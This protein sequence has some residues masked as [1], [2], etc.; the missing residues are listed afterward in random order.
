MSGLNGLRELMGADA[1]DEEAAAMAA[2]LK[3]RGVDPADLSD[4]QF[5]ALIPEAIERAAAQGLLLN[6]REVSE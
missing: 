5:F 3:E 6:A 1:T 4:E 2:I